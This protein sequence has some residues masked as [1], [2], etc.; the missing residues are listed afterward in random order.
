M[1]V[2]TAGLLMM[3]GERGGLRPPA[4]PLEVCA[5]FLLSYYRVSPEVSTSMMKEN[6]NLNLGVLE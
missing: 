3:E 4:L 6:L 1:E 5:D 2:S